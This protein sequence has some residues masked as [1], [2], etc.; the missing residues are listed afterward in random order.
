MR[1]GRKQWKDSQIIIGD[2]IWIR[3]FKQTS[4][5]FSSEMYSISQTNGRSSKPSMGFLI[6]HCWWTATEIS[7]SIKIKS[8]LKLATWNSIND[9]GWL[10]RIYHNYF[11]VSKLIVNTLVLNFFYLVSIKCK[12]VYTIIQSKLSNCTTSKAC[13]K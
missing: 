5:E 12:Y 8:N 6:S 1:F 3:F 11:N 4:W 7:N 2:G 13:N 10:H 9:T